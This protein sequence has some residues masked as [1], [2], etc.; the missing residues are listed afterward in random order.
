MTKKETSLSQ[1]DYSKA[2]NHI[3]QNLVSSLTKSVQELPS[4]LQSKNVVSQALASFLAN[5][6]YRQFPEDKETRQQFNSRLHEL[7][8]THLDSIQG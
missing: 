2:M 1:E 6:I 5:V 7:V 4:S 3:G 8:Q